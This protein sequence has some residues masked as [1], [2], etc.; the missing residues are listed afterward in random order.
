MVH[1]RFQLES[2]EQ[3][4]FLKVIVGV[5][6]REGNYIGKKASSVYKVL[7]LPIAVTP[8]SEEKNGSTSACDD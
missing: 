8:K 1:R 2:G 3:P 7:L 5:V 6:D 4:D